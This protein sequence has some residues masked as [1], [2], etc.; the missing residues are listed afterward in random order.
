MLNNRRHKL[1]IWTKMES[2]PIICSW[3]RVSKISLIVLSFWDFVVYVR[4]K[5][6]WNWNWNSKWNSSYFSNRSFQV[7]HEQTDQFI[8]V[9]IWPRRLYSSGAVQISPGAEL[10]QFW[11]CY[12]NF[13]CIYFRLLNSEWRVKLQ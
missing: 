13:G 8:R 11:C 2:N 5:L 10:S 12:T 3:I 7:E 4:L 6:L 1:W 9:H